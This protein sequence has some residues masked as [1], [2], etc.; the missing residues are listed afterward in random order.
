MLPHAR[1]AA[2]CGRCGARCELDLAAGTT[3]CNCSFCRKAR[4]WMA[5]AKAGEF[6]LLEGAEAL[7]DYQHH[8]PSRP[9]PFLHF[10]FCSR[11]GV[12]PFTRGGAM[13]RFGGEFFAVNVACLDDASDDE[14]AQAP[15][16]YADGRND[17]WEATPAEVRYL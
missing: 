15:I 14:L 4:F 1:L 13:P 2:G 6:R 11:C 17:N 12:R 5:F 10:T 16:H 9:A 8:P 3:R 7:T